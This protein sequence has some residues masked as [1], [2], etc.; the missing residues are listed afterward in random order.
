MKKKG[1]SKQVIKELLAK[2]KT[3]PI[4]TSI[5]T[6]QLFVSTYPEENPDTFDMISLAIELME[7]DKD[8]GLYFDSSHHWGLI[9]GLPYNLDFIIKQRKP[10]VHFDQIH[11]TE[12]AFPVPS[13][14]LIINLHEKSICYFETPGATEP[15]QYKCTNDQWENV[16]DIIKSCNFAQWEHEYSNMLCDGMQWEFK[17]IRNGKTC[18]KIYGSN[19]Y[20]SKW[21]IFWA[22]KQMC[23]RLIRRETVTFC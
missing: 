1:T 14:N 13:Q 4:G 10:E 22:L 20:P 9:E 8:A 15:V 2:A 18:K 23:I 21:R 17:L 11:Y 16:E 6:R 3:L 5:T 7:H 19:K 12:S